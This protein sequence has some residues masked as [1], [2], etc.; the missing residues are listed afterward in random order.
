MTSLPITVFTPTYNRVG[1]V[2]GGYE[3]LLAQEDAPPFEWVVVDDGST[4]G[5]ADKVAGW[6]GDAPFPVWCLRQENRGK[7]VAINRG[8]AA[9]SGE[10]F[11]I[12]DSDDRLAPGALAAVWRHWL[13]I[14]EGQRDGFAGV[15]GL[16]ATLGGEVVGDAFPTSPLDTDVLDVRLRLRV[17]GD[18]SEVYRTEVLRAYPFPE[19]LG[20]FVTEGLVWNRIARRHRMRCVNDVFA[21]VDYQADGLSARSVQL[22]TGAPRAA[23]LY[24]DELLG[25]DRPLPLRAVARAAANHARFSLHAGVRPG[26]TGQVKGGRW[27]RLV[28]AASFPLGAALYLRDR[29]RR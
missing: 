1:L 23:R 12:L 22:R 3:S 4:D 13:S 21:L 27:R 26:V 6:A 5:T 2:G 10:L 19:D 25:L 17:R 9:A 15:V 14:P 11:V 24:Y 16:C 18:K 8:V 20:R 29:L 28:Y 7:H